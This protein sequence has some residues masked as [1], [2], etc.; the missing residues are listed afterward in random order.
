MTGE[1]PGTGAG[2][3]EHPDDFNAFKTACLGVL[4]LKKGM[5]RITFKALKIKKY[6]FFTFFRA[7]VLERELEI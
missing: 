5:N 3:L 7:L 2:P 6:Y 1:L 4:P